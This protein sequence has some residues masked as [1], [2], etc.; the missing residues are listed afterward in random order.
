MG[1]FVPDDNLSMAWIKR[2]V[3]HRRIFLQN[4]AVLFWLSDPPSLN[5]AFEVSGHFYRKKRYP[6]LLNCIGNVVRTPSG[7]YGSSDLGVAT[8]PWPGR[9]S[10]A[11]HLPDLMA[12]THLQLS[13]LKQ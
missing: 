6:D 10:A 12:G 1:I 11:G 5:F 8:P 4:S 7:V 3:T 13:Q 9:Q 2:V